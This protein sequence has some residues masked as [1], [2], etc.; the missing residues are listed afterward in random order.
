MCSSHCFG[1]EAN[2]YHCGICLLGHRQASSGTSAAHGALAVVAILGEKSG[3][4]AVAPVREMNATTSV[5]ALLLPHTVHT[6]LLD[7]RTLW[8]TPLEQL[9]LQV[10]TVPYDF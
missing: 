2:G 9:E 8:R 10:N 4:W 5:I 1:Q 6:H 3:Q 7:S